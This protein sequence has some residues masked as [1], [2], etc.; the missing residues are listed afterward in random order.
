MAYELYSRIGKKEKVYFLVWGGSNKWL[1]VVLPFFLFKSFFIL[2]TKKVDVIHIGD[3][4]ISPMLFFLRIFKK[5]IIV[6]IHALDVT[7]PNKFYQFCVKNYLRK[8]DKIICISGYAGE[9][10]VKRGVSEK[11]ISV[12]PCGVSDDFYMPDKKIYELR[13]RIEHDAGISLKNKKIILS[14]GRLVKRKGFH[15]FAGNVFPIIS[16]RRDDIIYIIAGEGSFR[17]EIEVAVRENKLEEKVIL[18]GRVSDETVKNLY[19]VADVFVMPNIVV[20]GDAEGFGLVILEAASCGL[21]VAASN[22]EGIKD[23]VRENKNGFLVE[24]QNT[25]AWV[26]KI[27]GLL[28]NENKDAIKKRARIFT[29]NNYNWDNIADLYLEELRI[30]IRKFFSERS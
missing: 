21:P 16:K 29:I 23:A 22:L 17:E 6:T 3:G 9:E 27:E 26:K 5:P 1:F 25:E 10:C 7:F 24:H 30:V 19:N 15:W 28:D 12:I 8:A 20:E 18:L 2:L 14:V 13:G 11:N 4:S